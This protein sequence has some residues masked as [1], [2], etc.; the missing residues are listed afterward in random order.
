MIPW[1]KSS[2][3]PPFQ[4]IAYSRRCPNFWRSSWPSCSRTSLRLHVPKFRCP[5]S[6]QYCQRILIP[7]T[8]H[9]RKTQTHPTYPRHTNKSNSITNAI[10]F[11]PSLRLHPSINGNPYRRSSNYCCSCCPGF[12]Y[13]STCS[14]TFSSTT[15]FTILRS[16]LRRISKTITPISNK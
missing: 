10:L 5:W 14:S 4:A 3:V 11:L 1:Y 2:K 13:G 16:K 9:R 15:K 12:F 6:H 7:C 8:F